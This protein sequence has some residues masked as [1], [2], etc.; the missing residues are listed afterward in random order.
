M[1]AVF[2]SASGCGVAHFRLQARQQR[3]EPAR[4]EGVA[5]LDEVRQVRRQFGGLR[6]FGRRAEGCEQRG[7]V[8]ITI[9]PPH[10]RVVDG[11]AEQHRHAP[12]RRIG[13]SHLQRMADE[14]R[15]H[16][17]M[18]RHADGFERRAALAHQRQHVGAVAHGVELR[19][20]GVDQAR[21]DPA[22]RPRAGGGLLQLHEAELVEMGFEPGAL[23]GQEIGRLD[24]LRQVVGGLAQAIELGRA[25][26]GGHP[27]GVARIGQVQRRWRS[28]LGGSESSCGAW[29]AAVQ[30]WTLTAGSDNP[31]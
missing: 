17:G 3:V 26:V 7:L 29:I 31:A 1:Q 11:H 16:A 9:E 21:F 5:A 2:S 10:R 25:D 22:A 4:L 18:A 24:D 30:P 15:E 12:R 20:R 13:H 8:A 28:W 14:A 6:V 27:F 19:E 23:L